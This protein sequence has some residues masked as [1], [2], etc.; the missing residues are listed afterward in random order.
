[1]LFREI[2]AVYCANHTEL[3][4]TYPELLKLPRFSVLTK[5]FIPFRSNFNDLYAR[6]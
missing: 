5:L 4:V 6:A 2:I 3:C 1:M